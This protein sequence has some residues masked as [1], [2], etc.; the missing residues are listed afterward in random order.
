M[1]NMSE[2]SKL[3]INGLYEFVKGF[4]GISGKGRGGRG[5][6]FMRDVLELVY[7]NVIVW[8]F[9]FVFKLWYVLDKN[10]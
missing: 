7:G 6:V 4:V 1:G 8:C 9:I 10:K 3:N 2:G 5:Y